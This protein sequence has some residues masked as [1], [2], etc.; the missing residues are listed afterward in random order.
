ME[1]G[2]SVFAM[3]PKISRGFK[4]KFFY[5]S[6]EHDKGKKKT[7]KT[8]L[9]TRWNFFRHKHEAREINLE[10]FLV[11]FRKFNIAAEHWVTLKPKKNLRQ[12]KILSL[13][14]IGRTNACYPFLVL[15]VP[16]YNWES[17]R[18]LPISGSFCSILQLGEQMPATQFWF[19]LFHFGHH[20]Y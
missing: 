17:K 2:N 5:C 4:K 7:I 13:A 19:F 3:L 1:F 14:I 15:S 18:Q 9:E 10:W 12:N 8:K 6:T 11:R 20:F 16:L